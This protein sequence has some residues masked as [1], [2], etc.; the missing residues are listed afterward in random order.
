MG[1]AII[2][3]GMG[4]NFEDF[5]YTQSSS[6]PTL[7]RP[8]AT[9]QQFTTPACPPPRNDMQSSYYSTPAH[10]PSSSS[11]PMPPFQQSLA[12]EPYQQNFSVNSTYCVSWAA[13]TTVVSQPPQHEL[14][15]PRVLSPE[16]DLSSLSSGSSSTSISRHSSVALQP[17]SSVVPSSDEHTTAFDT[18]VDT[19]MKTI[20][21]QLPNQANSTRSGGT[22]AT[23]RNSRQEASLLN[24]RKAIKKHS[25]VKCGMS[26]VQRTHLEIHLRKHSGE[27]PFVSLRR[28]YHSRRPLC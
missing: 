18:E 6:L 3:R 28:M 17:A 7:Q 23:S 8:V 2:S 24:G 10:Y 4:G 22:R 1:T 20:Q 5:P 19:L 11:W 21:I 9:R 15:V 14:S 13:P 27:K 25:C 12:M 26:F 16:S